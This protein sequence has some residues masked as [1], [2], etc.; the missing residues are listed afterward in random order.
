MEIIKLNPFDY[1]DGNIPRMAHRQI[2][3]MR[4]KV[5]RVD[6]IVSD[7]HW[8]LGIPKEY[9]NTHLCLDCYTRNAD[10]RF[11]PWHESIEFYPKSLVA[12]IDMLVGDGQLLLND[13]K[14]LKI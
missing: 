3:Q 6:F 1:K 12:E 11:V 8:E 14:E 4:N 7:E 10:E 13:K 9:R 5:C 2:C